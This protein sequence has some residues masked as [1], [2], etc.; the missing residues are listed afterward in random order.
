LIAQHI[1]PIEKKP[2]F[3]FHP[4][5]TSYSIATAGCNFSCR[6]CQNADISQS[7]G[8]YGKI[9][10]QSVPAARIAERAEKEGCATI[11]YTYT[12][13]TVFMEYA[14]DVA[15]AA[16]ERGLANVFVTNGYMSREALDAAAPFLGAANVDLKAFNDRFYREQCGARLKPVL[17]TLEG[18]KQKGVWIEVTT[19]IIQGLN[20]SEAE[21]KELARFIVGL[22]PETPW[23]VSRFYPAY[24][25]IDR[26]PTPVERIARARQIGLEAGLHYVYTGNVPGDSGENTYCHRC[27][28]V[29]ISRIGYAVSK[30]NLKNG[31]CAKCGTALPGVGLD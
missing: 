15:A 26:G 21:L 24:L 9:Y 19:L 10:G 4:G 3:H 25:L 11:S 22:G 8:D 18:L 6:F 23:H 16:K 30:E 1:D 13:P 2:L 28:A 20:D 31:A 29:I 27:G 7:P 12:E 14:L 5:T 17:A